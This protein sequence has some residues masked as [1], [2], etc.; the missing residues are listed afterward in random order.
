MSYIIFRWKDIFYISKSCCNLSVLV[1][2]E[3][4]KVGWQAVVDSY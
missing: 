1:R 2:Y 4:E 3:V